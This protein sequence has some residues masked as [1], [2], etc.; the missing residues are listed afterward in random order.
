[1]FRAYRILP[2]C[3]SQAMLML[4][5]GD[6]AAIKSKGYGL[7]I[8]V[9]KAATAATVPTPLL[10]TQMIHYDACSMVCNFAYQEY[11]HTL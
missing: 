7:K 5:R 6:C 3:R 2:R 8:L 4:H 9:A 10:T 11:Q 1:M